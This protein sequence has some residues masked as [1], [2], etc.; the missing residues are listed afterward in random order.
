MTETC[1][2]CRFLM[3]PTGFDSGVPAECRR[4]APP[5][6]TIDLGDWCGEWAAGQDKSFLAMPISELE[7]TFRAYNCLVTE[8]VTTIGELAQ[9]RERDLLLLPNFGQTSLRH[10][11]MQMQ[12]H[13]I[14]LKP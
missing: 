9:M 6:P 4:H 3:K 2:N 8:G 14:N 7:L 1:E 5:W 13:G 11:K 12:K 10:T